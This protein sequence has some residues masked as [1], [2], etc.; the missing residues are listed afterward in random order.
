MFKTA[1]YAVLGALAAIA[2]GAAGAYFT[3]QLQVSDSVIRAGS[4]AISAMPTSSPLAID[5]LAPGTSA[6]RPMSVVND[7]SLA[8]DIIVTA[9]K[10][11]GITEFYDSLTCTVTVGETPL[12]GGTLSAMRTV[13]I[14]L[15]PGARGDL[16]FEVGLPSDKGNSLA[17]DYAKVALYVDAEQAH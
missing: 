4:V 16:K 1:L 3:A 2:V 5:T 6:V 9:K 15:A 14:R 12:Y 10:S 7:G 11:A 17:E 8:S 13:P